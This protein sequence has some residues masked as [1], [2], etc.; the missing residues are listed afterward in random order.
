MVC[1]A[2]EAVFSAA[3]LSVSPLAAIK[4]S[5]VP[6]TTTRQPVR[7]ETPSA[8]SFLSRN[9]KKID[10]ISMIDAVLS[11]ASQISITAMRAD[12]RMDLEKVAAMEP[13]L[14]KPS[15]KLQNRVAVF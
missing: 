1:A 13:M 7:S 4:P 9:L 8:R 2:V 3:Q 10:L 11:T 14:R 12:M 15:E 6:C 5:L